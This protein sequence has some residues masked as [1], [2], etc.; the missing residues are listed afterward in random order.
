MFRDF[1]DVLAVFLL[2]VFIGSIFTDEIAKFVVGKILAFIERGKHEQ[3]VNAHEGT[4]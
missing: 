1:L 3:E 2:G 4:E